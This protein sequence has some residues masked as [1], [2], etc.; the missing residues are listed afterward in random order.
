MIGEQRSQ[1]QVAYIFPCYQGQV[2]TRPLLP[3]QRQRW[4]GEQGISQ[5][6][7]PDE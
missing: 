1:S 2:S 4:Q 7:W 6:P 5:G 3:R